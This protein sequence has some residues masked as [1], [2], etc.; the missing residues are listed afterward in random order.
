MTSQDASRPR[1]VELRLWRDSDANY[2]D[3]D[4]M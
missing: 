1:R 2:F 4:N 3:G